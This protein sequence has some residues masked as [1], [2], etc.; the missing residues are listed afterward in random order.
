[1]LQEPEG[2]F[3]TFFILFK[4]GE[5]KKKSTIFEKYVLMMRLQRQ[6]NRALDVEVICLCLLQ[7]MN[8]DAGHCHLMC[9]DGF[10][11]VRH[12]QRFF[13]RIQQVV[14]FEDRQEI[15]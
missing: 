10:V 4:K 12:G 3:I 6:R 11:H 8:P 7:K 2:K 9:A 1:M 14:K 13:F 15:A 5:K